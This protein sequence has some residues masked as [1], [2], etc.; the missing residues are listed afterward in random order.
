M[1]NNTHSH[2]DDINI[3]GVLKTLNKYKVSILLSTLIF[4]LLTTIFAYYKPNIYY[5]SATIEILSK[6]KNG[7][8]NSTDY[9]MQALGG[10]SANLD[11]EVTLLKSRLIVQKALE[12]LNLTTR[13]Y[14]TNSLGKT[15]ELYK[16]SPFIVSINTIED[17]AY[18]KRIELLPIDNNT[19]TLI[20][21]PLSKYS[22][23]GILA[24][25]GLKTLKEAEKISYNKTHKYS[26]KITTP[27]FAFTVNKIEELNP[28]NYSFYFIPKDDLYKNYAENLSVSM[29]SQF[30]TILNLNYEDSVSLRAKEILNAILTQYIYQGIEDKAKTAELTLGFIDSQLDKID[31]KLTHSEQN[32]RNY[33][34][35]NQ[36][37]DLGGKV[38]LATTQVAEYEAEQSQLQTEIN[39]LTNLKHFVDNNSDLSGLTLGTIKFASENLSTLV[40]NLQ[41]MTEKK[42]LMLVDYTELHPEVIKLTRSISS[43][44]KSIKQAVTSS[45]QQLE[46]RNFDLN[47]VITKHKKSLNALPLQEKELAELARPLKVNE[48]V[49]EFLLEKKAETAILKSSTI[50]KARILDI[51]RIEPIPIKPKRMFIII[52]GFILGLIVGI[53]LALFREYLINTIRTTEEIEEM[54]SLPIYGVIP[55]NKDKTTKNIFAESFRNIRTKLEFLPSTEKTK[56]ISISSSVS[57]EGKTTIA[58]TLAEILAQSNKKVIILD[59]DLRKASLHE[60]FKVSNSIGMSNFLTQQNSFDEV[61]Q[62]TGIE[63]LEIITTGP[64]PANPSELILSPVLKNLLDVLEEEYDYI[65]I[66]TPPAGLVTDATILMN[67]SDISLLVIRTNYTRKE[68]VKNIDK[69]AQEHPHHKMGIILNGTVT[70]TEFGYGYGASYGYGYGYDESNYYTDK[71]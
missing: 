60:L 31:K 45:L 26:E 18:N 2:S 51:A 21:K 64:L 1:K 29:D 62:K 67:Y 16:D 39:I 69:M 55:F 34:E 17:L 41:E 25:L 20:I 23:K 65:I 19:F 40:K 30:G 48:N 57:G 15:T 71:K 14:S 61:V 50:A 22:L 12:S 11:N 47:E 59:L 46:Q 66:D 3:I 13:Y 6:G 35:T 33:K 27:W 28:Y 9:M 32:L 37:V 42:N 56:I 10:N 49:Y 4:V 8:L 63:G 58:A 53:S 70:G 38:T 5:S 52:I 54:T 43:T 68:F 24:Q 36:V 44:K 7:G